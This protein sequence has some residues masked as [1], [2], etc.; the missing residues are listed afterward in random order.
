MFQSFMQ[1]LSVKI[2]GYNRE[3]EI[4]VEPRDKKLIVNSRGDLP[5]YFSG[6]INRAIQIS[7]IMKENKYFYK[8][9]SDK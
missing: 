3:N 1:H 9:C 7:F 2:V 4:A 8:K 5:V 6:L